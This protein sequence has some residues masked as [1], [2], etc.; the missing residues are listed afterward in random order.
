[1]TAP[2]R[3]RDPF[4]RGELTAQRRRR[5]LAVL[6]SLG[7]AAI[8]LPLTA[9]P[10]AA[11]AT[12][13]VAP[14]ATVS[15]SS[16]NS[17]TGQTAAKAVD[18]VI[19]GYPA[20]YTKEWATSGG[21]ANSYLNLTWAAPV[22]VDRVVLFDRPNLNDRVTAGQLTFS[23]GLPVTVGSLN[24]NGTAT[25]VTFAA[26]TVTSLRFTV[27]SVSSTTQN[28]GLAE[29]QVFGTT[30]PATNVAPVANA[31]ADLTG[32]TG[33][34]ITL[35]GSG[36]SDPNGDP[37]TY[38][39]TAPPSVTLANPSSA[40]PSFTVAD[41]GQYTFTLVVN[42]GSLDSAA[43]SVVV[44]VSKP[45]TS[46]TNLARSATAT[47]SSQNTTTGQTAAKAIDGVRDGYPGDYTKEWATSGGKANSWL[48]LEWTSPVTI[49]RVILYDRPNTSD[50]ITG[51]QLTFSAGGPVTFAA[52]NNDGTATE[53]LLPTP[54]TVKSLRVVITS[55][56]TAT[57]NVGLSEI[58]AF[59]TTAPAVN[60]APVAS[61]GQDFGAVTGAT[62]ALDGS[63]SYD[64]DGDAL[65]YEWTAPTG[66][67]LANPATAK[68]SFT[69]SSKGS[70]TFS[71]VV[72][73]GKLSSTSDSVVV[74]VTDPIAAPVNLAPQATP[75][76]SSQNTST[77]QTAAKAVDGSTSGYPADYTREW[78]T[79]GGKAGS[80]LTLTWPG[81]VTVD[82]VVLYDRP[83]TND[84][85]T[86][87][88]LVFSHGAPLT[89]T[90]L[91]NN[92]AA[93]EFKLPAPQVMT[94][95]TLQI[96]GV[97]TTTQNVGLA[98]IEVFGTVGGVLPNRP[99]VARAGNPM[100]AVAGQ[101]VTLDGSAS[102]DPDG[103][104]L[105]Y[106]WTASGGTLT[107]ETTA[108]PTFSATT[109]GPYTLTL[110]VND[111]KADSAPATV[112]VT[113][114]ANQAPKASAGADQTVSPGAKVTLDG[115]GTDPDKWPNAALSYEWTAPSGVTLSS[116]TDPKPTFTA[117]AVAGTTY[118]FTLKVSDGELSGSDDVVITVAP[119]GVLSVA[120][121]G[122]GALWTADFESSYS[123][124]TIRLQKQTIATV[125]GSDMVN[126]VATASWVQIGQG[127]ADASGNASF[128]V[129]DPLEVKHTYRAVVDQGGTSEKFTNEV[130]YAPPRA[131]KNTGLAT[132]YID[133]NE[134][135]AITSKED[136]WEGTF[137][138]DG[139]TGS[140][141]TTLAPIVMKISGR[142]NSTWDLPKKPY[143]FALK[144]STNLCGMG[145]NKKWNLIANYEDS[146]FLRNSLAMHMGA[147]T[148]ATLNNLEWT[149]KSTP[150]DVYVNGTFQ[151]SYTLMDRVNGDLTKR[152][153]IDELKDNASGLNDV[154]PNVT[155]G[156]LLEWDNRRT[157]DHNV[158]VGGPGVVL[159][160]Q[161]ELSDCKGRGWVGIKEP[162]DETD[163]SGITAAQISYI[164]GYLEEANTEI[165]KG[166]W[167]PYIDAASTVDYIIAMEVT[168]NYGANMRSSVFMYKK[169]DAD[170][171]AG[172]QGKLYFGP[173]WDFDTSFGNY[174]YGGPEE[175]LT[176]GWWVSEPNDTITA[177]Q[178]V[179]TWFHDLMD[180]AEFK[181]MVIDRWNALKAAGFKADADAFIASEK[182]FVAKSAAADKTV[183]NR[184]D[185]NTAV[186]TLQTWFDGRYSWLDGQW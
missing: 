136:Y 83:N 155:G 33:S 158:C 101:N 144:D 111:G 30:A 120:A 54:L 82:R 52:L 75:T 37:L 45:S 99:P 28:I 18:G 2:S 159:Q 133:T 135:E 9:V 61:A 172:D 17:S 153:P 10:A 114:A 7:L 156:Y 23:S 174:D 142:G 86:G 31:G 77:G 167:K 69:A 124:K 102:S 16:Q 27:T 160:G 186:T 164:D 15:A 104:P 34:A 43:D 68:P 154:A 38:K 165:A 162:E 107:N 70:F 88:T 81:T 8:G 89:V 51:G 108:K 3:W 95:L 90:A 76:A 177:V 150:V 48:N 63:A 126:Y 137:T 73:D 80:S 22:V 71:L 19:A 129:A 13:N 66:I 119:L 29:I 112:T 109:P 123:G 49:E 184:S 60:R 131:T 47:A 175:L 161:G 113:V 117:G 26:R 176:T 100:S 125:M 151:G 143:K 115:A 92:G 139:P 96:S 62:V 116:T 53:I 84:Q 169:R 181:Q 118:T 183:W 130:A 97:A 171:A 85:I 58:E 132:V 41:A 148:S 138:M 105:T 46:S 157:S 42:D 55:V 170:P 87:G 140:R 79:S 5:P 178:G 21:R 145:K 182:A 40:K 91:N 134:S 121:S 35:D 146:T 127:T 110:V 20:D 78:A 152:V 166:N 6:L 149:P 72:R 128:T 39:W 168:K 122:T 106:A 103:N 185:F 64:P 56:A 74:T 12:S 94:S 24:D 180:D 44:T 25:E 32:F 173:L 1:M 50:R 59:G 36:S 163:G 93:T 98:E 141:C 11:A 4:G 179:P 14:Q 67:T 57:Q 147:K 65:T